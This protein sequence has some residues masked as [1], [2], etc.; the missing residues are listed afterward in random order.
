MKAQEH[1]AKPVDKPVGS[2]RVDPRHKSG[3]GGAGNTG[4]LGLDTTQPWEPVM[5]YPNP[6]RKTARERR[7]EK[8]RGEVWPLENFSPEKRAEIAEQVAADTPPPR[9]LDLGLAQ[10]PSRAWYEWHWQR[11]ID[12]DG[13]RDAISPALRRSV[14]DR[15]GHI[16]Q[17]CGDD[18][19]PGDIHLDHIKPW[20][21]G[22]PTT[23]ANLQVAHSLCNIKKG[24]RA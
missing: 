22:G 18:V 20:S 17:L 24:A 15:D 7:I 16:C 5:P 6:T 1:A 8:R 4:V 14:I 11:G 2:G 12:P 13:R 3:P 10:I 23:L 21:K 9:W 19:E